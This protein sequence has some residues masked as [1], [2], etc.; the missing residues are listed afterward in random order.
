MIK[1]L[2]NEMDATQNTMNK[3]LRK[4]DKLLGQSGVYVRRE[5]SLRSSLLTPNV[6]R[7]VCLFRFGSIVLYILSVSNRYHINHY[8]HVRK[9]YVRGRFHTSSLTRACV[10]PQQ[11]RIIQCGRPPAD[12]RRPCEQSPDSSNSN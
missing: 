12:N 1:E 7:S 5:A 8:H 3:V 2:D 6:R 9:Y 11:M 10:V 4:V